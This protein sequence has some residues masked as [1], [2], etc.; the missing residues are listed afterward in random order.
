M[1]E[2]DECVDEEPFDAWDAVARVAPSAERDE[3]YAK[4]IDIY[5]GWRKYEETAGDRHIEAF[6]LART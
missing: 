2:A 3:I 6:V 4:G 5:P 1:A